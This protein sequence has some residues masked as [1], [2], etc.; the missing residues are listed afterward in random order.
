[1]KAFKCD[2]CKQY[3]DDDPNEIAFNDTIE[4]RSGLSSRNKDICGKCYEKFLTWYRAV[5]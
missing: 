3:S 5:N 4:I 2:R 1:M